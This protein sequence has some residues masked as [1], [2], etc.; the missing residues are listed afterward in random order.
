M[1]FILNAAQN[2][3]LV[4]L[5]FSSAG[6]VMALQKLIHSFPS[7]KQYYA[8]KTISQCLIG[9]VFQKLLPSKPGSQDPQVAATEVLVNSPEV[10]DNI[11][12]GLLDKIP[13]II[14]SDSRYGMRPLEKSVKELLESGLISK[15]TAEQ[16]SV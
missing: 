16:F 8:R 12:E 14:Q 10:S 2:G 7:E 13:V 11:R 1:E 9:V 15:E 3:K 6:V 5:T 4:L